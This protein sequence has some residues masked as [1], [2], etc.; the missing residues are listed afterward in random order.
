MNYIKCVRNSTSYIKMTFPNQKRK[1][2]EGGEMDNCL[3][4]ETYLKKVFGL[5]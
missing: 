4:N 5:S 2:D 3:R 1:K